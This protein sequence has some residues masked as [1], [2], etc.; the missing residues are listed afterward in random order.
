[1]RAVFIP[2]EVIYRP[3]RPF[4]VAY[5]LMNGSEVV[6]IEG[7]SIDLLHLFQMA[8]VAGADNDGSYLVFLQDISGSHF[9]N[10]NMV[11]VGYC[12]EGLE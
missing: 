1:M 4:G 3:L 7:K 5:D 8:P 11:T 9:G 10:P 12:A 6:Q 2:F